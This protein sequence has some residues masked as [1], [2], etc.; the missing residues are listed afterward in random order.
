MANSCNWAAPLRATALRE[1]ADRR[2]RASPAW[3]CRAQR[4]RG[5][6]ETRL[7][8]REPLDILLTRYQV[9]SSSSWFPLLHRKRFYSLTDQTYNGG[10]KVHG[11]CAPPRSRAPQPAGEGGA[12]QLAHSLLTWGRE[13]VLREFVL[14]MT[15]LFEKAM[16]AS[17]SRV[18]LFVPRKPESYSASGTQGIHF[19][20]RGRFLIRS[21]FKKSF[22]MH[23]DCPISFTHIYSSIH[24]FIMCQA[25]C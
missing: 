24:T 10:K 4:P 12:G 9:A 13:V 3:S 21:V 5:P 25:L 15:R 2:G 7:L 19:V 22:M 14:N 8:K 23:T 17:S 20:G 18:A 6:G 1:Q 11:R 16:K